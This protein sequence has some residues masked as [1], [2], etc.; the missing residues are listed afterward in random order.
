MWSLGIEAIF[1]RLTT[2]WRPQ[3]RRANQ[4]EVD[5]GVDVQGQAKQ[6]LRDGVTIN[7]GEIH[8]GQVRVGVE[9]P[10]LVMANRNE[11]L[12]PSQHTDH[13]YKLR[14]PLY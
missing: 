6:L 2:A 8:S 7:I 14:A 3:G 11:L 5:P 1:V 10:R 13:C 4:A 12:S 9:A